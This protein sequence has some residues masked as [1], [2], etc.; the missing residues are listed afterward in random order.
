M[1][2]LSNLPARIHGILDA[3]AEGDA[4]RIAFTDEH[5]VDWSYRRLIDTVE[6][7][8]T[9]MSRLGIRP[10]DRVMIVCENSIAAIVLLYASSRLDAWAVVTNARLSQHE[11][12]LIERDC[13]P[14]RVFYT[15]VVSPDA[16]AHACRKNADIE[17]I[18][19]I[20][21]IKVGNLEELS[22][23]EKVHRDASQQVAVVIYTTGTTG[24]PKGVMLSHRSLAFV[25]CRGR[26]TDTIHSSDVSLCVMPISHSYGLTLMQG[27]LFAGAHLKI[28]PR[29]SLAH[30]IEAIVNKT[31]TIFTAVPALL[32][33][34]V[35]HV[36]QEGLQLKPNRLRY[37]YTGTAP[38]DLALRQNVERVFGVVL[39]NGYGLTETSPTISRTRYAM[40]S[41]EVNIGP[42]I[43]GV[44]IKIVG[45]DG[46]EVKEGS[47]GELLV[48][49]PN[50]ML[51]YYG[52]PELTAGV[53]DEQ[54]YLN[55]GDIVSRNPAG[56]LIMQGRSK[57]LIIRSGFNVYPPEIEAVL[58]T[59]PTVL[60]SAVVGR[61]VEGN[62]EIIAF[63]E[64]VPGSSVETSDLF[65]F[66]EGQLARYKK[67]QKIVVM[68]QLPIAPNGKIRKHDLKKYA[69]TTVP[70][71]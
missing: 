71:A 27:M 62:E 70:S 14:R 39:H 21:E 3:G 52:Q 17:A 19:G 22:V 18:T 58:N 46:R 64:P 66:L 16:D 29:F 68:Q 10:G 26:R 31:L 33:R 36:D 4:S 56:D 2:L 7:A 55:T 23:A 24:R 40:G 9:E 54:G 57:E 28:M 15:H 41:N 49:G 8:A 45:T 5:D 63:V 48:R 44:E 11:L 1:D 67:P 37:V 38:L 6:L 30:A 53:I 20:G 42:P 51:G 50:V 59:H 65:T 35:A 43:P 69:E 47:P 25:A 61:S 34:V 13:H 12:E 60:N 32:S